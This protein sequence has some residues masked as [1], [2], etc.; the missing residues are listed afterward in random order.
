MAEM[1]RVLDTAVK[2]KAIT[3]G[4]QLSGVA[5]GDV[6]QCTQTGSREISTILKPSFNKCPKSVHV[7]NI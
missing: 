4:L 3:K 1:F 7:V 2:L 5:H 6:R